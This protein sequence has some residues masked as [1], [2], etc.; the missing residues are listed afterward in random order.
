MELAADFEPRDDGLVVVSFG[1]WLVL[2]RF[3]NR[4]GGTACFS[5]NFVLL[6][7]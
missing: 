7:G 2:G 1:D 3:V 4:T 5:N 6:G